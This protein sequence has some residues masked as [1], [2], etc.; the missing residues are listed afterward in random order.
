[1]S[2][3]IEDEERSLPKPKIMLVDDEPVVT[4][5][6]KTLLEFETNYEILAFQSPVDAL[7][8]FQ[9]TPVDVVISDSLM[10]DMDGLEF[11]AEIKKLHPDTVRILLT[12]YGDKEN[13]IK[14]VN[15]VGIFQYIEK[16]W[17]NEHLKL[18]IRNA[19]ANKNLKE[20][21]HKKIRA[22]DTL[23]LQ[24]DSLVQNQELFK[25]ELSLARELQERLLPNEFPEANGISFTAKY[26]P[27]LEVGGDFYDVMPLA[28]N[29]IAILIADITG[30][31]IQAALS[32]TLLKLSFSDFKN[33]DM[34]TGDILAGMNATL[35]KIL[36][37][38]VF[39]AALV[40][41]LDTRSAQ[42]SIVNGGIPYPIV[43][44]R[45]KHRVEPVLASGLVLGVVEKAS[46]TPGQ[47]VVIKLEE[48]DS[49]ILYTDGLSEIQ[50]EANEQFG[51]EFLKN[52]ILENSE[53]SGEKLIEHLVSL[54]R[55]FS[56][57]DHNWDDI[58]ILGIEKA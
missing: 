14:A 4:D 27:A 23:L 31:G 9:A 24:R 52:M 8:M 5:S 49:L 2:D 35:M 42:C 47:E 55:R 41:I 3:K 18:V 48:S 30:H 50:N 46:Y 43:L 1:M 58:T 51:Y 44:R 54:A 7:K 33:C 40:V 39:V 16:P 21:L 32:T 20:I 36:P 56:N 34:G 53:K 38:N 29:R 17:D 13:A 37:A 12:G 28:N 6:L 19:L 57:Q 15:E 11:L 22:L 25:E 45:S 10:A 26:L